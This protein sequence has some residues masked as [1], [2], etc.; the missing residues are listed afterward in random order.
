M[1]RH[2]LYTHDIFIAIISYHCHNSVTL[3]NLLCVLDI[4]PLTQAQKYSKMFQERVGKIA[5]TDSAHSLGGGLFGPSKSVC[6]FLV[7]VSMPC[8]VARHT[9]DHLM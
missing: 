8:N 9:G 7:T 6:K 3:M 4:F 1:D 2:S 5:F